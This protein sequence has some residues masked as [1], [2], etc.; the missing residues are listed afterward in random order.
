M[1]REISKVILWA[2]CLS[3]V[4][5][6]SAG[7]TVSTIIDTILQVPMTTSAPEID[8]E[9]GETE[10]WLN[11][12]RTPMPIYCTDNPP[13]AVWTDIS[14]WYRVMWDEDGYYFFGHVIDDEISTD[15]GNDYENDSWEIYFDAQKLSATSYQ[16]DNDFQWR[17]VYGEAAPY[18]AGKG[19][20]EWVE[21]DYGYD[22]EL[23]IEAADVPF[24]LEVD[25]IFGWEAQ[26]NDRDEQARQNMTKWH[27]PTNDS[28][29]NPSTFGTAVTAKRQ[30]SDKLDVPMTAVAPEIDGEMENAWLIAP[31]VS[32]NTYVTSEGVQVPDMTGQG[33]L[34]FTFRTMWDDD[35]FY[36]FGSVKD[37]IIS[38]DSGNDYENDGFEIYFD[39]QNLKATSYQTDNDFQWRYVYGEAPPYPA[40]TG[41]GEWMET[42]DGYD[43]ELMVAAA[44]VPFDLEVDHVFGWEVQVND[45]ENSAR[46]HMGKYM[47]PTNDSW[48]N[49]SLFGTAI[50]VENPD[51]AVKRG[52][53]PRSHALVKNYPNPFNPQTTIE[54]QLSK[55]AKA[56]LS[57]YNLMGEKVATMV[58]KA[59]ENQFK[60][61]A[62]AYELPSGVY[63]YQVAAGNE[64]LTNKM[65]L[66]K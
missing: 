11:V 59:G 34:D 36:F 16:T 65:M 30:V 35:G 63:I 56:T 4:C 8:G 42:D 15:S 26:V 17:Y 58:N 39:A 12:T 14:S 46:E 57:V 28:W 23:V 47:N 48:L 54:Y 61:D 32:M 41:T 49:P 24:D 40:G 27:E 53:V 55:P 43:F 38:T 13:P 66:L 29:L 6:L 50:L 21:T 10:A 19:T 20:G 51:V 18:P 64:I 1:M 25:H 60:F 3:L 2:V 22:F 5:V 44:D 62:G 31:E 37:D 33:D 9:M 45:R 7:A 52:A